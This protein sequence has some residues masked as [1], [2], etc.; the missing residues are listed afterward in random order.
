L[1]GEEQKEVDTTDWGPTRRDTT[2]PRW[3]FTISDNKLTGKWQRRGKKEVYDIDLTEDYSNSYKM[4]LRV[5]R[6][7]S[8]INSDR[9]NKLVEYVTF[10]GV[11]PALDCKDADYITKEELKFLAEN[12]QVQN[13][14]DAFQ[15][16]GLRSFFS[17]FDKRKKEV[18]D[19][20]DNIDGKHF[21]CS[22][23]IY[24]M[25]VYN[26]NGILV[27]KKEIK[28]QNTDHYSSINTTSSLSLDVKN[29]KE[30]HYKDILNADNKKLS[31]LLEAAIRKKYRLDEKKKLSTWLTV[32][33]IPVTQNIAIGH[34]GINFTYN[35]GEIYKGG[36][37]SS[38]EGQ[39][40]FLSYKQLYSMLTPA[41]KK[42]MGL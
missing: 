41:F 1:T 27:L 16:E 42:R 30:C 40:V 18:M 29:K 36:K 3:T 35:Y 38:H 26:D 14:W 34:K 13:D 33:K 39:T 28:V 15:K 4:D 25:P 19:M 12:E 32:D 24:F 22:I 37:Y 10:I 11:K 7:S 6:D 31:A 20:P 5:F 8:S 9:N 21:R 17:R 23:D 2:L